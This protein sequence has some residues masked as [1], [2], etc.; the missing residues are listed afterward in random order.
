[1]TSAELLSDA[2]ADAEREL[3]AW[4][5]WAARRVCDCEALS[6][7]SGDELAAVERHRTDCRYVLLAQD[8]S[9]GI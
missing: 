9:E 4:K 5:L 3:T 8:M 6:R 7:L 1:M 2:L